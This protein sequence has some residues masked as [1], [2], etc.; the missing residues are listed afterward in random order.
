MLLENAKLSLEQCLAEAEKLSITPSQIKAVG[1]TNQRE[2]TIVWDKNT[3]S[4]LYPAIVWHDA[5]TVSTMESL[6]EKLSSEKVRSISGL[7]IS[8]YFSGV[9]L[10]WMIENVPEVAAAFEE[11]TALFGTVDT[12]LVWNLS[13]GK[14]YVT[15]VTNAGRT[16]MMNIRSLKWDST[17]V[18]LI[19]ISED[20]LPKI[21]PCS[22]DFGKMADTALEGTMISG[23]IGDQQSA[24]VGQACFK[25]GEA[26]NTYGT[27]CFLIVNTG[28]EPKFTNSYL[29][30]T[31]GYK[32]GDEPCVYS[33]EGS[34]A[35]AG[36]AITWLRDNLGI[37]GS[38][39]EVE[40]L[41]MSV[42]DTDDVYVVP[43][44]SGF[45]APYWRKD[46]RGV[47][48]G[49]TQRTTK[50]HIARATLES[51]AYKTQKVLEASEKD[52]GIPLR[53]LR[54][55]GGAAVNDLLMQMQADIVGCEVL[56]PSDVETT[57]MGAAFAAGYHIRLY[58][59]LDEFRESRTIDKTFIPN[60]T[61]EEREQKTSRW[62]DAVER[63][64]GWVLDPRPKPLIWVPSLSVMA[65]FAVGTAI[66]A[67]AMV[68]VCR[69]KKGN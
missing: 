28:T 22:A 1:I 4:P 67:F 35:V 62:K 44:F 20:I 34:I 39:S 32:F 7:P 13:G 11:G 8:T 51:M 33:L 37:I 58:E 59:S 3:G 61:E 9:K 5:R 60:I 50:A 26:K 10:R 49:I 12:W 25:A 6:E 69:H 66:G 47:I 14:S 63:S 57:A 40:E 15:D 24:L 55:D 36:A 16:M 43:A 68:L 29:L 64:L 18:D 30:T 52:M 65:G 48:V 38:E 56:R 31:P 19:G 45:L 54:V 23:V 17:L 53:Q 41:A 27:G 21:L 46:A 2:T 42:P